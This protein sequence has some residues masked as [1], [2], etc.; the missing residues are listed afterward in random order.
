METQTA[1]TDV[2]TGLL[3]RLIGVFSSPGATFASLNVQ[4]GLKDWLIPLLLVAVVMGIGA[5]MMGPVTQKMMVEMTQTR[6]END[7]N[8]TDAKKEQTLKQIEGFQ[9]SGGGVLGPVM[10]SVSLTLMLF[11]SSAVFLALA[12]FLLG[13]EATY[14]KV[15]AVVS[16]SYL[17]TIP[18]MIVT[19]PLVLAQ[20]TPYI[21]LGPGLLLPESMSKTYLSAVL[22]HFNVFSIW[23]YALVAIG[24]AAVAGIS[25]K[26]AVWGVFVLFLL[27]ALGMGAVQNLFG[28]MG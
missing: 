28:G 15:L 14:K 4:V 25:T 26:K 27:F 18:S 20:G 6:L 23:Q 10:A 7:P 8:M 21:Q 12:N 2:Q 13:G 16:L 22:F 5:H 19:V 11:A 3:S 24:L 9:N 1:Q 17:I